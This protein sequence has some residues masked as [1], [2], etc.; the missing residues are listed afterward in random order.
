MRALPDAGGPRHRGIG[1]EGQ[2][3]RGQRNSALR[4]SSASQERGSPAARERSSGRCNPWRQAWW[5]VWPRSA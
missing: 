3:Y 1:V 5:A 2:G 4:K